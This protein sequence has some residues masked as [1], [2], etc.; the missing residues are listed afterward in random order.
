MGDP[1]DCEHA[2][3]AAG[4][5]EQHTTTGLATYDHAAN[6]P[7]FHAG[8]DNSAPR[9]STIGAVP[10]PTPDPSITGKSVVLSPKQVSPVADE[11]GVQKNELVT[12]EEVAKAIKASGTSVAAVTRAINIAT[13]S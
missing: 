7:A 9:Q 3:D 2:I 12:V 1:V 4:D 11:L 5:T 13:N 10:T 6:R 8:P